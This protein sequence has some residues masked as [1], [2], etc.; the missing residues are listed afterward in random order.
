VWIIDEIEEAGCIPKMAHAAKAKVMMGNV[1]KTDKLDAK[2][3]ATLE[4]L[5]TLPVVWLPPDRGVAS[6]RM[7]I[8]DR[9]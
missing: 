9:V 2:G 4:R 6:I 1:D 7:Q 3:L 8:H 5:G